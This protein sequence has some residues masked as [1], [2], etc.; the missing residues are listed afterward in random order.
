VRV[1]KD[2]K[3]DKGADLQRII[4]RLGQ[5]RGR[6][7]DP[8]LLAW[9]Q[10]QA[11]LQEQMAK[12]TGAKEE[13]TLVACDADRIPAG[14]KIAT[15]VEPCRMA[16]VS[17]TFPY[18]QQLEE[19]RRALKRRNRADLADPKENLLP[20]FSRIVVQRRT[21]DARGKVVEDWSPLDPE[22]DILPV[23]AH[24]ISYGPLEPGEEAL[25]PVVFP[26]LVMSRPK[27][28]RGTY[29]RPE[30]PL[31]AK[32]LQDYR[33]KTSGN[34]VMVTPP[35][36]RRFS[37]EGIN[38]FGHGGEDAKKPL[39]KEATN[40]GP[41]DRQ[42]EFVVPEYCLVRFCDVSVKPGLTYEYQLRLRL[43][44]PNYGKSSRLLAYPNLGKDRELE[45]TDW[46]PEKPVRVSFRS[47]NFYYAT[48]LDETLGKRLERDGKLKGD[49]DV[50]FVHMQ[51]WL[52]KVRLNPD[53]QTSLYGVGDWTVAD[54]PVRRGE[55]IGGIESV[56][57]PVW[58]SARACFDFAVPGG[59]KPA[60][61]GRI[62]IPF[63][64]EPA[65]GD[66]LVDWEG[67]KVSQTFKIGAKNKEVSED[68]AVELLVL[69]PDGTLRVRNSRTDLLD[70]QR[71]Q[72][73]E[74][75]KKLLEETANQV[76][77][78][79]AGDAPFIPKN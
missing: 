35:P 49:K 37:G 45:A 75:W 11:R 67:G 23:L 4:D 42:K 65:P 19:F 30:L 20:R 58:F 25:Q 13:W 54:V 68:A 55:Y 39:P 71:N 48:G 47:E 18:K 33:A 38:P 15:I 73:D 59:V 24:S 28:A 41:D 6:P 60:T 27:P 7:V 26:G 12:Q 32:G 72:R 17:A 34:A 77:R 62:P 76:R 66:L 21:L 63:F 74:E 10:Q 40:A 31:L 2:K 70:P 46:A 61:P 1:P 52:D 36:D 69:G 14:A 50:T 53:E 16:M 29:P 3:D 57:L 8:R 9:Y 78:D 56:R 51:R 22:K 79:Q 43:E 64:S 44:N 5:V